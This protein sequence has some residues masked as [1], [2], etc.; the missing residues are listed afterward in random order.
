MYAPH[1]KSAPWHA[2]AASRATRVKPIRW[3]RTFTAGIHLSTVCIYNVSSGTTRTRGVRKLGIARQYD[4]PLP[5]ERELL[6]AP[7]SALGI[8]GFFLIRRTIVGGAHETQPRGKGSSPF[9]DEGIDKKLQV[10]RFRSAEVRRW[11]RA[12]R[13]ACTPGMD[14]G[15]FTSA[16]SIASECGPHPQNVFDLR[17]LEAPL[18]RTSEGEVAND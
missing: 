7:V 6:E 1:A 13:H 11:S 18:S 3:I 14:L 4:V 15:R 12:C 2:S 17:R 9:A 8:N 16:T 5:R 10:T